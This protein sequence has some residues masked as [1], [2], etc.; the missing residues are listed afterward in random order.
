[1]SGDKPKRRANSNR[2]RRL[3]ASWELA[4]KCALM[5]WYQLIWGKENVR[6]E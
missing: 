5:G 4:L 2:A 3:R 1:M 6:I